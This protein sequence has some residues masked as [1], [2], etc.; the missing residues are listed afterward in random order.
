[1]EVVRFLTIPAAM[2]M[3]MTFF[4]L[5][6][7]LLLWW[8]EEEEEEAAYPLQLQ[9]PPSFLIYQRNCVCVY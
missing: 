9:G 7:P 6:L 2:M 3:M 1:M 4:L 5:L 8:E